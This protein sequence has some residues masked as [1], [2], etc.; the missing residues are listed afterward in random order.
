VSLALARAADREGHIHAQQ[1]IVWESENLLRV[2]AGGGD[3]EIPAD[4]RE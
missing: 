2:R 3:H 4:S 1:A